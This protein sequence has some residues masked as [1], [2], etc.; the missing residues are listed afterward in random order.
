[1]KTQNINIPPE[2]LA[3][4]KNEPLKD[5]EVLILGFK[6]ILFPSMTD[7]EIL[8]LSRRNEFCNFYYRDGDHSRPIF[9]AHD[10]LEWTRINRGGK[11][12]RPFRAL[13]KAGFRHDWRNKIIAS[14]HLSKRSIKGLCI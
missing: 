13:V 12:S 8:S 1:M 11:D 2:F 14:T 10:I 4:R 7:A 3:T 5:G 9:Q 6:Q